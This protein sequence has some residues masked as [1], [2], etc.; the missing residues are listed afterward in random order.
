MWWGKRKRRGTQLSRLRAFG[1]LQDAMGRVDEQQGSSDP[2]PH[3]DADR[4]ADSAEQDVMLAAD[5]PAARSDQPP[6]SEP[7][8]D[9]K[10]QLPT[11][12]RSGRP[13]PRPAG[14]DPSVPGTPRA[15]GSARDRLLC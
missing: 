13:A 7:A 10:G 5:G 1:R 4:P 8:P 3:P 9:L 14:P 12:R 6:A 2:V 15:G 11:Q